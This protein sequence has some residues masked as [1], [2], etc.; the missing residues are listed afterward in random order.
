MRNLAVSRAYTYQIACCRHRE[1]VISAHISCSS[2]YL[3]DIGMFCKPGYKNNRTGGRE[4]SARS[5][6]GKMAAIR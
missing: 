5:A 4:S 2:Q 1:H 6:N 3:S